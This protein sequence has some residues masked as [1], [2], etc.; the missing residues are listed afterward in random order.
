MAEEEEDNK[1]GAGGGYRT[2]WGQFGWKVGRPLDFLHSWGISKIV[3][4]RKRGRNIVGKD[5]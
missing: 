5:T 2:R 4:E 1:E 3:G